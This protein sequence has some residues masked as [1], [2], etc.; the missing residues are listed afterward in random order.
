MR[1]DVGIAPYESIYK[2]CNKLQFEAVLFYHHA[3]RC[4]F[5]CPGIFRL[6]GT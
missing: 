6:R 3:G 2:Q 1:G 4:N 5:L